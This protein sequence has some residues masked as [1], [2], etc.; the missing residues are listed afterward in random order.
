M[1]AS[2]ERR[3]WAGSISNCQRPLLGTWKTVA[4]LP[5]FRKACL[6]L[7]KQYRKRITQKSASFKIGSYNCLPRYGVLGQIEIF[8]DVAWRAVTV[9]HRDTEGA[10]GRNDPFP[11]LLLLLRERDTTRS[12]TRRWWPPKDTRGA[13]GKRRRAIKRRSNLFYYTYII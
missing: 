13:R 10:R 8:S 12:P 6:F 11:L 3:S 2:V 5:R 9:L 7:A 4:N 1:S